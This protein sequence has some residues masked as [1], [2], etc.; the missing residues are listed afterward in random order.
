M[1]WYIVDHLVVIR[2]N[3]SEYIILAVDVDD[4]MITDNDVVGINKLKEFI[5]LNFH[6]KEL[7]VLEFFLKIK[8]ARS[9]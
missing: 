9:K 2:H 6:N 5:G 4:I 3:C 8:V 1:K 7:N